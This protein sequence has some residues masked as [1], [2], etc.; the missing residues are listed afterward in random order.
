LKRLLA[1]FLLLTLLA[2]AAAAQSVSTAAQT[3][4]VLPF[5]NASKTPGLEW[6]GESFP[7]IL[8]ER[9]GS[10]ALYIVPRQDRT[11][12]F[13]R[14]GIPPNLRPS[15]ATLFQIGEQMD[16]DYMVVGR[17]RF[18]GQSFSAEARLL[19]V[20]HLR[21]STP[22]QES[23][24]LNSLIAIETA[25]ARNLLRTLNPA[26]EIGRSEMRTDSQPIRLDAFEDYIRGIVA[27]SRPE[28]IRK[29]REAL[30]IYPNYFQAMLQLGET[31]FSAR[32]YES[33]A[34]W[35]SRI[36]RSDPAAREA[37]FYAGLAYFYNGD[38]E[39]AENALGYLAS[40][41]PLTEVY[42][43]LGVVAAR[44]G[45]KTASE[46]FQKAV[47]ADAADP[48][49]RFNLGL[50][51][52]KAGDLAGAT[53]Q[54]RE[55]VKLR[56]TDADARSL[57]DLA[58]GKTDAASHPR[59]PSERIKR[60]YDETSFRQ[61]A[62]EIENMTEARLAKTDP[63]SHAAYH[64]ERGHELL[65]QRF[66]GE[67]GKQFREAIGLD[68]N[69][70]AAHAGLAA[71]LE[72][73]N[74]AGGARWE[75]NAALNLQPLAE[76]YLVLARLDL[77]D[78]KLEAASANA[79]RAAALQPANTAAADLKRTIAEKLEERMQPKP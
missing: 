78:N 7:E 40:V 20:K 27:T 38:F 59:L 69:N 66:I 71:V 44:R 24:P 4:L 8:G 48:D 11:Y 75:A 32:E 21:L 22:I 73:S 72:A 37:S 15:H 12:A 13:D 35:L 6:I 43:D 29:F 42:N 28:R 41:F 14:A 61:L 10:A 54:L 65:E 76:A 74:D 39:K 55:A 58:S 51:L 9:M 25:L 19:D 5:E 17:Y 67:A 50:T 77:R 52:Y 2:T 70:A 23:G 49:Y 60:N 3:L 16:V 33:A 26:L 45:K 31:Y 62:L 79:E 46:Y 47:Q 56:P 64:V 57:L 30:R 18:D 53:R 36:P 68:V 63:R 34:T 1:I